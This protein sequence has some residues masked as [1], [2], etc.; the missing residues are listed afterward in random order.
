MWDGINRRRF[1]R[2]D[3]PCLIKIRKK[4][5]KE[6]LAAKTE[7]LGCGGICAIL[8]KDLGLFSSVD[9]EL[10]LQDGAA[11]IKAEGTVVWVVRRHEIKKDRAGYF[12]T[13]IEFKDLDSKNIER[14][15]KIVD[16]CLQTD[17]T[18]G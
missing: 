2:A 15:E 1:P 9:I 13:G 11:P 12:D 17:Q 3:Y 6:T 16:K 5:G 10:D 8:E 14:I 18:K 7:N 4:K